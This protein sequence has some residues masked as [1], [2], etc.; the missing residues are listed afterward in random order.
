VGFVLAATLALQLYALALPQFLRTLFTPTMAGVATAWKSPLWFIAE[1][2]RGLNSGIP[3]GAVVLLAAALVGSAGVVSYTRQSR[4]V[5]ALMMLP[6]L[7]TAAAVLVMEHNLWP[8]F[9]FFC[10]GFAVLI[11]VRG[12]FAV[13][14]ILGKRGSTVATVALSAVTLASCLTVPRAWLPKQDYAGA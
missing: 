5:A 1:T 7:L 3:G 8:R 12:V 11:A 2:V 10:A 9:F 14:Q 6:G 13:C 4:T